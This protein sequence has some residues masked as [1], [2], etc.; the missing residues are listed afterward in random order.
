M[1]KKNGFFLLVIFAVVLMLLCSTCSKK[2]ETEMAVKYEVPPGSENWPSFRGVN[3][4]GLAENQDLPLEWDIKTGKNIKWSYKTPGLG[5]SS[6]VIWGKR[7]FITTAIDQVADDSSLKVGLYGD[8]T[9]VENEYPHTW[10]VICLDRDTG[11][12]IWRQ[13]AFNGVPKIKRHPKSS[14]ASSTAATDGKHVVAFFGSEGLYC[15][16]FDGN[17]LWKRDFGVLDSSWYTMPEAQW[18]FGSSPVIHQGV[19]IIQVDVQKN[20]FIAALN[21]DSGET[22]WKT[23]RDEIPTWSTPAIY[24]G[25]DKTQV[26]VNG[27]KHIGSYNFLTGEPIW[28]IKGGGDIPIPTPVFGFGNVYITSSHGRMR[29]I[30]AIKLDAVGDVTPADE[31]DLSQHISWFYQRM[32]AYIPTPIIYVDYLYVCRI[33]GILLCYDAKTGQEIYKQR[34]GSMQSAFTASPIAADGKLYLADEYGAIHIVEA[35]PEYIHLKTNELHESC[36]STPSISGNLLFVRTIGHLFAIGEGGETKGIQTRVEKEEPEE[37]IDFSSVK[38]DGSIQEPRELINIASAKFRTISSVEY[39]INVKGAEAEESTFGS[40]TSKVKMLGYA[41]WIPEYFKMEGSFREAEKDD[42]SA[43]IAGSDGNE[44]YYIDKDK[45]TIIKGVE[46]SDAGTDIRRLSYGLVAEFVSDDPL[47]D[48]KTAE[49]ME[50]SGIKEI[51]GE[52]CY[53]LSIAFPQYG[54][55]E[56]IWYFSVKDFLPRARTIKYTMQNGKRGGYIQILSNID[57]N[58]HSKPNIFKIRDLEKYQIE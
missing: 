16:D 20:S 14:H 11:K 19:V 50:I 46:F 24:A 42:S 29:P 13:E 32:G 2:E 53:E 4:A 8:V 55:Y 26:V 31:K 21:I 28:W 6:P 37:K 47:S 57:I 45:N 43:F 44:F 48:E 51:N 22:I 7:V 1:I 18:E 49:K 36:L 39:D 40:L 54:N 58:K 9:S 17:L 41:S 25:G 15:Y 34:V 27:Y 3:G 12:E 23:D 35:G 5:L 33:N 56:V 52:E 38:T 10:E 30:Y